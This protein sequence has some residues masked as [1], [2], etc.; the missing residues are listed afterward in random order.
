MGRNKQ[1]YSHK[2]K[3]MISSTSNTISTNNCVN[4]KSEMDKI[5]EKLGTISET[6]NEMKSS[7]TK[8]KSDLLGVIQQL[9]KELALKDKI[10][11]ELELRLNDMEQYQKKIT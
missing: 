1:K 10:I 8:D 2:E 6:L 3:D 11:S 9:R 5:N 4:T 7:M